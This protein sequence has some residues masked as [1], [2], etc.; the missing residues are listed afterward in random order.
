MDDNDFRKKLN[1][2]QY[3]VMRQRG[4]EVAHTGRYV[5]HDENG[6]Y[7]CAACGNPVF[8]SLDK[9]DA[10]DGWPA[11][12]APLHDGSVVIDKSTPGE[13]EV[14]CASC[15]SHFG[16]VIE[17]D[18]E[19]YFQIN[20]IALGF[21]KIEL[22]KK[23][24]K[25]D[26]DKEDSDSSAQ[27]SSATSSLVKSISLVA[28]GGAAGAA[29]V[30]IVVLTNGTMLLCQNTSIVAPAATVPVVATPVP[31][32]VRPTTATTSHATSGGTA[33]NPSMVVTEPIATD[34][35]T[36][37]PGTAEQSPSSSTR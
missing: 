4:T 27:P 16:Y 9:L 15:D 6:A 1:P 20:S 14:R 34:A 33:N 26:E 28:V 30:T 31:P 10:K 5:N 23:D 25:K 29:V 7:I 21:T 24:D 32:R 18:D 37:G 11:F 22:P 35:T 12:S 3:R 36:S 19:Q 2:E 13:M 8:T 17:K